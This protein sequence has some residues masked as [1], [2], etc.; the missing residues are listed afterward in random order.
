MNLG[1]AGH[2]AVVTGGS[3]GLGAGMCAALA[4]EG[5]HVVVWDLDLESAEELAGKIRGDGLSAEAVAADVRDDTAVRATVAGLAERRGSIEILVNCAGLSRDA[6]LTEMTDEQWH[7]VIDICLTGPFRVSR[8]IVPHMLARQY[9]RIINISSRARLGDVNKTNYSAAKA[10]LVGFTS[11]LAI[12]LA[13]SGITVNAI[14]PGYVET[15]RTR[16]LPYFE[17]IRDRA[18]SRTFTSRS[19]QLAD[20]SDAVLYLA[21]AQS[22]FITGEV[23]TI[24]GGRRR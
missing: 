21:A 4:A 16:S 17:Q 10:G 15:A 8:A 18:M 2:V 24:A 1:I 22:G 6:P 11:A 20:I 9:G 19:G 12:E 7:T 14:A 5:A 13:Q 3:R 23:L